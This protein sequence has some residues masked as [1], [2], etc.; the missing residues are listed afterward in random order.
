MSSFINVSTAYELFKPV[1]KTFRVDVS[2]VSPVDTYPLKPLQIDII[3]MQLYFIDIN[4][5]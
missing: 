5:G 2:T 1:C 4:K 3:D